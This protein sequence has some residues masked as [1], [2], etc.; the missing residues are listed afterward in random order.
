MIDFESR[1]AVK[2]R[3][4][5]T[6]VIADYRL[7]EPGDKVMVCTSG[8]KDSS[9]LLGLLAE[10][11][12]RAPYD[13]EIEAVL[14]DQKQPG[15]DDSGYR[16]WVRDELG[17]ELTVLAHDTYSIVKE[18]TIDRVYCSL[19]SR[20]RR[21]ILYNHAFENGFTKMALGHHREDAAET[22]LLNL[23]YTGKL[24]AMPPK[25]KS[26]DGRN[27]VIRPLFAVAENDLLELSREWKVP[28]IPCDLCGSQEGLKRKQ[29]K[30][31]LND[32]EKTIPNIR[33]SMATAIKN[34]H[35]SHLADESVW[36]FQGLA[37]GDVVLRAGVR[38]AAAGDA[39]VG[40]D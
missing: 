17:I 8:G 32:L 31:L 2:V 29:M 7:I 6:E 9:V 24:Q 21:G 12:R 11:R 4:Q 36:D 22:L 19:C 33:R 1:L 20:L 13:F 3:K 35:V 37:R 40:L 14:L 28:T 18:K 34:V 39:C 27:I 15:F 25:F 30:N 5:I 26:D 23:F 16:A 38:G 10:T